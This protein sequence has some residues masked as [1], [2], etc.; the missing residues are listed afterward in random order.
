MVISKKIVLPIVVLLITVVTVLIIYN[1]PPQAGRQKPSSAAVLSV[2]TQLLRPQRFHI[3]LDSYGV[4]TPRTQSTLMSQVAGQVVFVNDGFR[5][6]GFFQKG[7]LLVAID[8]SDYLAEVNIAKANLITAQQNL[9]EEMARSEQAKIDWQRL[10]GKQKPTDLVLRIPQQESAQANLTS[11]KA[12]LLK[13]ELSLKRTK[14]VAPYSGRVVTQNVDIGSVVSNNTELASIYATDYLEVRLAINNSDLGF[15]NL[16]EAN[17]DN[18]ISTPPINVT[19][20]SDLIGQ[21]SWTGK[22]VRTESAIDSVS[23]QLY[24]V[25]QIDDPFNQAIERGVSI[26]IGEYLSAE[27]DGRTIEEAIVIPVTAIY[28]GSYVYIEEDGVLLRKEVQIAWQN[29]RQAL[30]KSGLEGGQALVITPLGQV[31]SGTAVSVI[32]QDGKSTKRLKNTE[33]KGK[34]RS[35]NPNLRPDKTNSRPGSNSAAQKEG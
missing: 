29:D 24:V 25:A 2:E 27:I 35:K 11:A 15:V 5:T 20:T 32:N 4:V 16:P 19:F 7:D 34:E 18:T 8:D 33:R 1:N 26:K 31:S 6:G 13:A 21:Q 3:T 17:I 28:Q 12:Q 22:I 14:I 10:G 9:A 30:I 23:R